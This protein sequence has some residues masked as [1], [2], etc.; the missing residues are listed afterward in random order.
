MD[1]RDKL[2]KCPY[3]IDGRE[4]KNTIKCECNISEKAKLQFKNRNEMQHYF[5][6]Y[7]CDLFSECEIAKINNKKYDYDVT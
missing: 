3:Y 2:A 7:C 4:E 5:S 1:Y 6:M